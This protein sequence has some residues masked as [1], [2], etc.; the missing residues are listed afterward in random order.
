MNRNIKAGVVLLCIAAALGI[1]WLAGRGDSTS[2]AAELSGGLAAL[3]GVVG[4]LAIAEGV[5]RGDR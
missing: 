3:S 5:I 2:D 4:F 1:M